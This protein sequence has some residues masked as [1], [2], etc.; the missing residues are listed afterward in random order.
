[1]LFRKSALAFALLPCL[2]AVSGFVAHPAAKATRVSPTSV[3]ATVEKELTPPRSLDE[4]TKQVEASQEMYNE[5][6]QKTYG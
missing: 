4:V 6:V 2:T 1:M 5:H 3:A